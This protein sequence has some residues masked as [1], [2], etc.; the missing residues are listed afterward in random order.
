[1]CEGEAR[2]GAREAERQ[3]RDWVFGHEQSN[4][5]KIGYLDCCEEKLLTTPC[6]PLTS[7]RDGSQRGMSCC[8]P[9]YLTTKG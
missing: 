3:V 6:Y 9:T 7:F 2:S 1:M 8:Y 4:E 5:A